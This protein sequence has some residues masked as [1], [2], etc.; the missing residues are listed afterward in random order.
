MHIPH[1]KMGK[2]NFLILLSLYILPLTDVDEPQIVYITKD[3]EESRDTLQDFN[4]YITN[5]QL[6]GG[7]GGPEHSLDGMLAALRATRKDGTK[8]MIPG[9]QLIV[10][11]DEPTENTELNATII[12]EA[13]DQNVCIHFFLSDSHGALQ[14]ES[15]HL[16]TEQVT[17]STL[18]EF[19]SLNL[20]EFVS[21][22]TDKGCAN[23]PSK[24]SAVATVSGITKR[25]AGLN[26]E[27]KDLHVSSFTYLL[28]LSIQTEYST[29]VTI[30]RSNGTTTLISIAYHLGTLAEVNPVEGVWKI[31]TNARGRPTNLEVLADQKIVFDTSI[32]FV[33]EGADNPSSTPP[34]LCEHII[35]CRSKMNIIIVY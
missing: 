34:P 7:G 4:D 21:T 9:S 2:I 27:C 17:G 6:E 8:L 23:N 12:E 22:Y 31:C 3:D 15:F 19:T 29:T 16:I 14:E 10:L 13:N 1:I 28:T 5:L 24:R 33:N 20:A 30:T 11:T 26:E 35:I 25:Q 18:Q 32:L